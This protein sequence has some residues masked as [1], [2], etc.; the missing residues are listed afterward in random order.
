M[1]YI[2]SNKTVWP[3]FKMMTL[4]YYQLIINGAITWK[5]FKCP[6]SS[7]PGA[8]ECWNLSSYK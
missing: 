5:E 3:T 8:G 1:F 2:Y 4:T 6:S 7:G